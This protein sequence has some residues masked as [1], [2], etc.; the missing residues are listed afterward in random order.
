MFPVNLRGSPRS[1]PQGVLPF[2]M[3][4]PGS[5]FRYKVLSRP[6]SKPSPTALP[7]LSPFPDRSHVWMALSHCKE[8]KD[9]PHLSDRLFPMKDNCAISLFYLSEHPL[10]LKGS[11]ATA[12]CQKFLRMVHTL[13]PYHRSC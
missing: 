10:Y 11:H 8:H 9:F 7:V 1:R 12:P 5:H 13:L 4:H 3:T 2:L 6:L